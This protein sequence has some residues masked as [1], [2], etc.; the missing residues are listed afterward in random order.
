[1]NNSNNGENFTRPGQE[2]ETYPDPYKYSNPPNQSIG[3]ANYISEPKT[4]VADNSFGVEPSS[5]FNGSNGSIKVH[6]EESNEMNNN[7]NYRNSFRNP[8][9]RDFL[10]PSGRDDPNQRF[11][12]H[13]DPPNNMRQTGNVPEYDGM[14][15]FAKRIN[16]NNIPLQFNQGQNIGGPRVNIGGNLGNINGNFAGNIPRNN[17][18]NFH[19]NYPGNF[20][21]SRPQTAS[22]PISFGFSNH[23]INNISDT[24]KF[25]QPGVSNFSPLNS[26]YIPQ[27]PMPN[28]FS[29][30][31]N[32]FFVNNPTP[33]INVGI[34]GNYHNQNNARGLNLRVNFPPYDN[35]PNKPNL[36][37]NNPSLNPDNNETEIFRPYP[38]QRIPFPADDVTHKT[39]SKYANKNNNNN[40]NVFIAYPE[41]SLLFDISKIPS[42]LNMP[43]NPVFIIN[44]EATKKFIP[45]YNARK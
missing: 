3:Q 23:G 2:F 8:L 28:K 12:M 27:A 41:K 6:Y 44:D 43:V 10:R 17:P 19:A 40:A 5:N 4:R 26:G 38:A 36:Q 1:M 32:P 21:L 39:E 37:N 13:P 20:P 29:P 9:T 35:N 22:D 42:N 14:S 7:L 33:I 34:N 30:P 31:L 15:G 24:Q 25:N 45:S 16:Y 11:N 18:V